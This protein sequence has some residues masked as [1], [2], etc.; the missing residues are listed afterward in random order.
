MRYLASPFS[1]S[2]DVSHA[3]APVA[4]LKNRPHSDLDRLGILEF[5]QLQ[6]PAR[7]ELNVKV[8]N[9]CG[10]DK[11][12]VPQTLG[13]SAL[14]LDGQK[15]RRRPMRLARIILIFMG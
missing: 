10:S 14:S 13:G 2:V 11:R 1:K 6:R 4:C 3:W 8:R 7:H 9:E 5:Q 15:A 12:T